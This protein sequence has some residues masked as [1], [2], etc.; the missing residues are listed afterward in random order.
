MRLVCISDTHGKHN[1][2]KIPDG[3]ILIHAG[4]I[5]I[6]RHVGDLS[7]F[8]NW[9]GE[10]PHEYKIVIPG[11]HDLWIE[12]NSAWARSILTNC[13]FLI[14]QEVIIEGIKF[15]G[16]PWQPEYHNWAWNLPRGEKLKAVWNQI[17]EDVEVLI[18]HGP[19]KGILDRCQRNGFLAGC[20]ELLNRV[21]DIKP[22]VHI[23]GHIH[24]GYGEC[25]FQDIHFVNASSIDYWYK[26]LN[27]PIIIDL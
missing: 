5:G 23:F 18:T 19:P 26:S 6:Q 24:E 17:P 7:R 2:L 10:L 14:D 8:N 20:E 1:Q 4:D 22:K 12:K 27:L 25:Y 13:E 21:L 16:S 9:L 11:N 15:W 3:D